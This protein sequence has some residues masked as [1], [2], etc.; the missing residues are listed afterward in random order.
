MPGA[1]PTPETSP[2]P[3]LIT[4][5]SLEIRAQ[6]SATFAKDTLARW[7]AAEQRG[8]QK[9]A[10]YIAYLDRQRSYLPDNLRPNAAMQ[11]HRLSVSLVTDLKADLAAQVPMPTTYKDLRDRVLILEENLRSKKRILSTA[12]HTSGTGSKRDRHNT[13]DNEDN[14]SHPQ[15]TRGSRRGLGT[16]PG[17]YRNQ[18]GGSR[19]DNNG[20][21]ATGSNVE[22][23]RQAR[24]QR[25]D[26]RADDGSC[27][28]CGKT[29]HWAKDCPEKSKNT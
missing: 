5:L 22:E 25:R 19:A 14:H 15:R 9:A 27:F 11:M 21:P 4:S 23:S 17:G 16:R 6:D 1:P 13:D 12:G 10:D 2:T 24:R 3:P 7:K 8:N 20:T 29:G 26:E 28:E 18:R